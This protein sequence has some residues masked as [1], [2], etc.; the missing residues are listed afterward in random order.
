MK[1]PDIYNKEYR[2]RLT[3]L[4]LDTGTT[5]E[6]ESM[7]ADYYRNNRPDDDE[8]EVAALIL[9][10]QSMGTEP[11]PGDNGLEAEYDRII[12]GHTAK[13]KN[14]R[15]MLRIAG[16]AAAAVVLLA[17]VFKATVADRPVNEPQIAV[18]R[19]A[20]VEQ[21]ERTRPLAD[22][23]KETVYDSGKSPKS[24]SGSTT[25]KKK[26]AV[27]KAEPA[28]KTL[29]THDIIESIMTMES[30]GIGKNERYEIATVGNAAFIRT[31]NA[32]GTPVTFMATDSGEDGCVTLLAMENI[33]F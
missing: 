23:P 20:T 7:L 31:G 1:T 26:K 19:K 13:A 12:N 32:D 27:R 6:E 25:V 10:L 2:R 24:D 29:S 9:S 3:G 21:T 16:V 33:N 4:W 8:R 17:V 18:V 15:I 28:K 30:L 14:R 5:I 11:L 22:T